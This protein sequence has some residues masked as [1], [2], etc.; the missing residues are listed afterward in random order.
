MEQKG[1]HLGESESSDYSKTESHSSGKHH[2]S[3]EKKDKPS[4]G[5]RIKAKLHKH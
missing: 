5:E 3:D 1:I 2:G 4:I